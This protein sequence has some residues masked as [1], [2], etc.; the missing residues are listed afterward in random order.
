MTQP[1]HPVVYAD[2]P[3]PKPKLTQKQPVTLCFGE[4]QKKQTHIQKH[5]DDNENQQI[6]YVKPEVA[7]SISRDRLLLGWKQKDLAIKSGLTEAIIREY[8]NGKAVHNQ[9]EYQ[10]IRSALDKGQQ[11]K[12]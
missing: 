8:E 12:Q 10:K 4:Q 1:N 7:A 2:A 5:I 11:A 3:K 6:R 9:K